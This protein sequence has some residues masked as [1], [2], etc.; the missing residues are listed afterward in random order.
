LSQE[1]EPLASNDLSFSATYLEKLLEMT[2]FLI[3]LW[4]I[5]QQVA[6]ILITYTVIGNLIVVYLSQELIKINQEELE[7]KG[8]YNYCLTHSNIYFL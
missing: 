8:D 1:I 4:S 3:I 2:D 6:V 5:S 7:S